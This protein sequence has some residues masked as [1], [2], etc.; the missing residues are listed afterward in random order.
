MD[1]CD[2]NLRVLYDFEYTTKYGRKI[3][4]SS[5]ER[6]L[7]IKKTNDDWWQVI[8]SSEERPFFVPASYV[9]EVESKQHVRANNKDQ[10]NT[11]SSI[12]I[13]S[14]NVSPVIS[15][16]SSVQKP[17][18]SSSAGN[19]NEDCNSSSSQ[20][21]LE[22]D[23]KKE[24]PYVNK[25]KA[26]SSTM[27]S[28]GYNSLGEE[29][30]THEE[31]VMPEISSNDKIKL[32]HRSNDSIASTNKIEPVTNTTTDKSHDDATANSPTLD[33]N[34]SGNVSMTSNTTGETLVSEVIKNDEDIKWTNTINTKTDLGVSSRPIISGLGLPAS[35]SLENLSLQIEFKTN[36]LR[37]NPEKNVTNSAIPCKTDS[38]SCREDELL[39]GI[40]NCTEDKVKQ[41]LKT[42]CRSQ[43][44][45]EPI[46][47][48]KVNI[49]PNLNVDKNSLNYHGSF[50][51]SPNRLN[52]LKK[53][54]SEK[55]L[56]T[57][58]NVGKPNKV[59]DTLVEENCDSHS[60][61][62]PVLKCDTN[63]MVCAIGTNNNTV[64]CNKVNDVLQKSEYQEK[65]LQNRQC[66]GSDSQLSHL[67]NSK[68]KT[69]SRYSL[70]SVVEGEFSD[71]HSNL[72]AANSNS[73]VSSLV[74]VSGKTNS[75][76]SSNDSLL[77][78]DIE[79]SF[80]K[81]SGGTTSDSL[82]PTDG[83]DLVSSGSETDSV[84]LAK[85]KICE[86]KAG[87]KARKIPLVRKR[88]VFSY[89]SRHELGQEPP[90]PVPHQSPSRVLGEGWSEYDTQ[91]G[92]KFFY[93]VQTKEKRWKPPRR[94][95][96][97]SKEDVDGGG[98]ADDMFVVSMSLPVGWTSEM[99]PVTGQA[100]YIQPASGAKWFS[101]TDTE[102]RVYFFEENSNTSS[103]T[104][105]ENHILTGK[106]KLIP[107]AEENETISSAHIAEK[108]QSRSLKAKSMVLAT[109]QHEESTSL[110]NFSM[111][112]PQ[113]LGGTMFVIKEGALN[114]T[115]IT[116]NGKRVRKN[117][118]STYAVLTE[119][120][121]LFFKDNKG[122]PSM[123]NGKGGPELSVDLNG[124]KIDAGD[125][126]SSRKNVYM[127]ST[128]LGLQVLI[129][130]D[131]ATS[132]QQWLAAIQ[133]II[134]KL[135]LGIENK[136]I[137]T[138]P[139]SPLEENKPGPRIGRS[140]SM[141]LKNKSAS[142]EDLSNVAEKQT[143]IRERLKKFF[144]RRPS[145]DVLVKKGIWK[146]EPVF[147]CLLEQVCPAEPPR[148]PMFVQHCVRC[149]ERNL[150]NMKTDG[151]YR[152]S[153]NISQVQKIRYQVDQN[154]YSLLDQE[155]DVHVLSGTLKLFFREL[156]QPL[157]PFKFFDK[158]LRASTNSN[159]NEKIKEFREIVKSLPTCNHDTLKY[160][161]QHL[162]RV[163]KYQE[164]NRM[165][166]PNIAIVFGPTLMWPEQ[167]SKNMA[168]D[169]MQQNFVIDFLL[170]EFNN[171]FR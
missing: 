138:K 45:N 134:N 159:Y 65:K 5:G 3:K 74:S 119:L 11:K 43:S 71:N 167:E 154:I 107:D 78:I 9:E 32:H 67:V 147:G 88:R 76:K 128:V 42:K 35:D 162:L 1:F 111:H 95:Y 151:L 54:M 131:C 51:T 144:H 18:L 148:V 75:E 120:L 68:E 58:S 97:T 15:L 125:K 116:E 29:G 104:L 49:S 166:I 20:S 69:T 50:K 72:A 164:F 133:K 129:Q 63:D 21:C 24:I 44:W 4:I 73:K 169:L 161:L 143:K 87:H 62:V 130:C 112:W 66:F 140:K 34:L 23:S 26:L 57:V 41:G 48:G 90:S 81:I 122:F 27:S 6:L 39:K 91:D 141:K 28:S 170:S 163:T 93:N 56:K 37:N 2:V 101:S 132:S 64:I 60:S 92:R 79:G 158:A 109:S 31:E 100:C 84:K 105:P 77:D 61:C 157:I 40:S 70:D 103:W 115:K 19:K 117:W 25:T 110:S 149:V 165:H 33:K 142:I 82:V 16:S 137:R 89:K 153:G 10:S 160:L 12:E 102:G 99:D 52:M 83:E 121:L 168:F 36:I 13:S 7:L 98:V 14:S 38:S 30:Q 136:G 85:I 126:V 55:T 94:A 127:L 8:R 113:L 152:V 155:E 17:S 150:E 123:M 108:N 145:V 106:E 86:S 135:P 156:K 114:K 80:R 47:N 171:I 59:S 139:E 22:K 146:D 124:A 53:S 118:T 96:N 46:D